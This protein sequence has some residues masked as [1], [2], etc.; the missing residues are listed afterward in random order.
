MW[1]VDLHPTRSIAETELLLEGSI[2]GDRGHQFEEVLCIGY[3]FLAHRDS[4][5]ATLVICK[6]DLTQKFVM[7]RTEGL[8]VDNNRKYVIS[9]HHLKQLKFWADV[10]RSVWQLSSIR[11]TQSLGVCHASTSL[12]PPY[13][14][15]SGVESGVALV[16]SV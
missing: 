6:T 16:T 15:C 5:K 3:K 1:R 11:A 12:N 10:G 4:V 2:V 9:V 14:G 7:G 8:R 13:F